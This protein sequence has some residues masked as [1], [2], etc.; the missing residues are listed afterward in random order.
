MGRRGEEGKGRERS[1]YIRCG[2]DHT[3]SEGINARKPNHKML[4]S[5]IN[6]VIV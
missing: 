5:V 1:V 2:C 6:S 3:T 4:H